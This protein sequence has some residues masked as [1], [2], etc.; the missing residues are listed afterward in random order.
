MDHCRP[1]IASL[2]RLKLTMGYLCLPPDQAFC[3]K[4]QYISYSLEELREWL[5]YAGTIVI[6]GKIFDKTAFLCPLTFRMFLFFNPLL[7]VLECCKSESWRHS[8]ASR[9]LN[10]SVPLPMVSLNSLIE[11]GKVDTR[12]EHDNSLRG[13]HEGKVYIQLSEGE[14]PRSRVRTRHCKC[15]TIDPSETEHGSLFLSPSIH[16]AIPKRHSLLIKKTPV[17]LDEAIAR[18]RPPLPD[19]LFETCRKLEQ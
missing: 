11:F 5:S 13:V 18:M 8:T 1:L 12:D 10:S 14:W 17:P 3:S 15:L 6:L 19:T 2:T 16:F 7:I 9:C 4:R